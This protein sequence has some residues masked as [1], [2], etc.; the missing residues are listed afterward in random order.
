[1]INQSAQIKTSVT[2]PRR[3][4]LLGAGYLSFST[5]FVGMFLP[6]LPTT[7]FWIVAA[8]CF[9]KS[10]PAMY[11]RILAWPGVGPVIGDFLHYGVIH[12]RSKWVALAGMVAA[13]ALILFLGIGSGPA[14]LALIGIAFAALYV[15]TRPTA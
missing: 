11:R 3:L 12:H 13:A 5:G 8:I 9:A 15:V 1:M 10:S 4:L 14:S 7:V 6:L 2:D